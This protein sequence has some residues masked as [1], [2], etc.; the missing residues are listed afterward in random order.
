M[1]VTEHVADRVA[2][3]DFIDPPLAL[4]V[5]FDVSHVGVAEQVV[6]VAERLLIRAHQERAQQVLLA[7]LK[8]VQLD[9]LLHV[10]VV[11]ESVNLAIRIAG[12]IS[13]RRLAG[14]TL[15]EAMNRRNREQLVDGPHI[16]HALED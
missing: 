2:L 10:V 8:V 14:R 12:Q 13:D 11:D 16:G 1:D 7:V 15:S 9:P 5:H 6:Q 4:V 3:N